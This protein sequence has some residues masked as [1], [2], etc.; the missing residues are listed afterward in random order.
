MGTFGSMSVRVYGAALRSAAAEAKAILLE[1]AAEQINT[2]KAQL[3]VENGVIFVTNDKKKSVTFAQL[4][5]G[6]K[7]V[8]KLDQKAVIKR[9]SE[10]TI[11]GKSPGS[12]GCP[13]KVTGQAQFAGDIR[14]PD[15]LYA[16]I[17]RP[18]AHGA[19]LKSADTSTAEKIPGW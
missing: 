12:R 4:A 3:T 15:L 8:R 1:M 6:Q 7:I 17:L 10:F 19:I 13:R 18:P 11:I 9:A 5:K 14:F 2:P 16:K